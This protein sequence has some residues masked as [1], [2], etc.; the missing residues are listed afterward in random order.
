M[1]A[2]PTPLHKQPIFLVT[3]SQGRHV[4]ADTDCDRNHKGPT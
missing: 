4:A 2:R 1:V 3:N